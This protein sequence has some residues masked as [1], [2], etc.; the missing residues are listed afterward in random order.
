MSVAMMAEAFVEK[1]NIGAVCVMYFMFIHFMFRLCSIDLETL[2]C[3]Y[4]QE[5][6][7]TA[8]SREVAAL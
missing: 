7:C 8:W 5:M 3:Q 2:Q 4:G 1:R 6:F